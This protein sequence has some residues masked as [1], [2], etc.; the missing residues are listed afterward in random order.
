LSGHL[1]SVFTFEPSIL[2]VIPQIMSGAAIIVGDKIIVIHIMNQKR[3]LEVTE[4]AST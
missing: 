3:L 1:V 2:V 4:A